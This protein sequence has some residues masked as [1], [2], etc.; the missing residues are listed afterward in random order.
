M[1]YSASKTVS[2]ALIGGFVAALVMGAIAYMMP[3][4]NTGGAPF[5]VAAAMAMGMGSNSWAAGWG[6][7]VTTGIIVGAIFGALVGKVSKLQLR[8]R[9]RALGLGAVAGVVVW[10]IFF[11]PLMATLMPALLGLGL[12]V[13]GSFVA[14]LVYGLVLGG[15]TSLAIPSG[16]SFKCPTCGAVFGTEREM[17]EHVAKHMSGTSTQQLKCPKCGATFATQ[18]ELM[19]HN[20]KAHPM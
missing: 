11:M 1:A 3:I 9:R 6:L 5:F 14:H 8:T 12:L 7:H 18:Q 4:P 10:V 15:V 19:D 16:G 2:Y 13:G 17:K 20:A